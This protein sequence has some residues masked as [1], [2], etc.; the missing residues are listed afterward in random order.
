MFV[1]VQ[2]ENYGYSVA[3]HVNY[4]GAGNPRLVRFDPL[5]ASLVQTGS[6]DIFR[7]DINTDT[8]RYVETLYKP[9]DPTEAILLASEVT[10][11]KSSSLHTE[12]G[13]FDIVNQN[14]DIA[15]NEGL[16]IHNHDNDYGHS[17]DTYNK[18]FALGCRYFWDQVIIDGETFDSSGSC[19][20]L[21]DY[22]F[23]ERNIYTANADVAT[24][25]YG[26]VISGSVIISS[27]SNANLDFSAYDTSSLNL[28][29]VLFNIPAGYDTISVFGAQTTGSYQ[30]LA[31]VAVTPV[32]Q[33]L[34]FAYDLNLGTLLLAAS[35]SIN[36][37]NYRLHIPNPDPSWT[38]SFG[39]AISINE[40]WLAVGSPYVS[41]SK[42]MVY[43]FKNDTSG[44]NLDY[45]LYQRI[46]ASSLVPG[47][48]FGWDVS[49]NKSNAISCPN[50]L[51]VG[52]GAPDNQSVYLFELSSS[53][54]IV[55]YNFT[56]TTTSLAPFP[57]VSGS[58]PILLSSS[59]VTSSFGWSVSTWEDTVVI[60]APSERVFFEYSGSFAFFEGTAYIF[61]RCPGL[62]CPTTAS[63]YVL[64]QKVYGDKYTLKDNR[65]GYDVSVY[66]TNMVLGCP[67]FNNASLLVS[68]PTANSSCY[69]KESLIQQNFCTPDLGDVLHGQWIYLLQN[70]SSSDWELQKTFQRK[71]HFL[72]PYR[73]LGDAVSVGDFSITVGAPML[74]SDLTRNFNV[75]YTESMGVSLEDVM[76]KAYIYNFKNYK[77]QF[78]VG[79]I[80]YRNGMVVVNTSGSSFEGLF[81]NPTSPYFY[82]YDLSY[83]SQHTI[84]EKQ[85]VCTVEP[86][87]FNVSTNPTALVL[88][89]S[90]FDINKNGQFDFQDADILLRY[91]Q[92]KN[93]TILGGFSFDWSSSLLHTDDEISFYK[94]QANK[95]TNTDTL[96]T[97]SLQRFENVDIGFQNLLDFNQDNKID[98]NDMN[99]MWKYFSKRLTEKNYLTFINS[100]CQRQ[101]VSDAIIY[102]DSLSKRGALPLIQPEFEH[103]DAN[104]AAD[105][106]GSFLAP[107]VT[108]IGLY[109]GLDLVAVAKLGSS[110]KL[111]K[112]LPI[113][114]VIK[115]DF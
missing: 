33:Y 20:D 65:L 37:G 92:Y 31:T 77:H 11:S 96:F 89:A 62:P 39:H 47:Q 60:G 14:K 9:F 82:E 72:S 50:R 73:S 52:C 83:Q 79:N 26:F 48:L 103:Y 59:Y 41:G 99:I 49:L 54:W 76:G 4:V 70:T 27:G 46:T 38:S 53:Q 88:P 87:E 44:S 110:I 18:R 15:V 58:A 61:E 100:N 6:V 22:S 3:T 115:L 84:N 104:Y 102:I 97:A 45:T 80:F 81:F 10:S 13:G 2:N 78:Y 107:M 91:M 56:P 106:T 95:F 16:Y 51:A 29:F 86:G 111:P 36:A 71:K 19:V 21:Y 23:S 1:V 28:F 34:T 113:N 90:S 5:T 17:L 98:V 69:L 43:I 67:K 40:D 101:Q 8:H 109:N 12:G 68:Q 30:K 63:N 105:R 25:A 55:T 93:S 108:T 24:Q 64:K 32:G 66:G 42:G 74:I 57:Y 35:G 114:F 112:T 75:D 94:F 7:Y 85:I